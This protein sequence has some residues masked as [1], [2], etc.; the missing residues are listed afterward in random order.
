MGLMLVASVINIISK[1]QP[2]KTWISGL[3]TYGSFNTEKANANISQKTKVLDYDLNYI[4]YKTDGISEAKIQ[5]AQVILIRMVLYSMQ[6][7]H[8]LA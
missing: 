2:V 4:Y 7:K 3:L 8:W 1:K 6:Y 5:Q